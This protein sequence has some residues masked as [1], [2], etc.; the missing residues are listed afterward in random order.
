MNKTTPLLLLTLLSNL[1]CFAQEKSIPLYTG[2]IPNS[3]QAPAN[4]TE[5][6]NEYGYVD[7]V[8]VPELI[9]IFPENGTANGT[10]VIICPGGGYRLI[11]LPEE[12]TDVA[13]E[14]SKAGITAFVLKYRLPND[15]I[16][17]DKS[18]G[19][20]Q[21]AQMA[22]HLVRKRASEWGLHPD[23]IGI[24]G[25]SAGGHLASTAGTHFGKSF[26][27]NKEQ[28]DLRPDFM[29]LIYPVISF[30]PIQ[31]TRTKGTLLGNDAPKT[32]IA[33]YSNELHVTSLTP[34]TFMVH[35]ADDQRILV[36]HSLLF[37]E[38]LLKAGVKTELHI[39]QSGGHGF[40][41]ENPNNKGKWFDWCKNWLD[42]NGF[43]KN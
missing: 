35:A 11:V 38:A 5:K 25:L 4:Y 41:L 2:N 33:Y 27:E 31:Q 24:V 12:G 39:F 37:H 34:P 14:F 15:T 20:L 10:A 1:L 28:I 17:I 32:K 40:G 22:I 30:G 19:P 18:I 23:K 36:Q 3:K 9:P 42:E 26:I 43:I 7:H 13:K 29:I 6:T 21:D 8:T 16:M